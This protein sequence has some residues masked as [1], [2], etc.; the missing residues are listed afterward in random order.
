ML[1]D[2]HVASFTPTS[3]FAIEKICRKINFNKRNVIV[4]YGPGTGVFTRYLL[5]HS[6]PDSILILIERNEDFAHIMQETFQDPRLFIFHESAENVEQ[7]LLYCNEQQADYIVSG[8]PFSFLPR[9]LRELIVRNSYRCLKEGGMFLGYQTF[10]QIDRFLKDH[11]D[12]DFDKVE[13]EICV[14]NV[15]P[16]KIFEAVK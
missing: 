11:L 14:L 7:L 16:L 5:A 13:T 15:P 8:I 4:E 12:C 6:T 3:G 10:F 9:P 2:K 1:R